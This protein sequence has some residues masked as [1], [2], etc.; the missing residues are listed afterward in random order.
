LISLS[1][2]KLILKKKHGYRKKYGHMKVQVKKEKKS[3]THEGPRK[4]EKKKEKKRE[5]RAMSTKESK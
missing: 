5:K 3:W 2:S 4:K 1:L